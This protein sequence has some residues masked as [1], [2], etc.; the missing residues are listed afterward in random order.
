MIGEEKRRRGSSNGTAALLVDGIGEVNGRAFSGD[1]DG[2]QY[3]TSPEQKPGWP[4]FQSRLQSSLSSLAP[5]PV[6]GEE[7]GGDKEQTSQHRQDH[8]LP[9]EQL[10]KELAGKRDGKN[11][12]GNISQVASGE[13]TSSL[14]HRTPSLTQ[15][16]REIKP[17]VRMSAVFSSTTAGGSQ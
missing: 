17:G 9:G 10:D 13:F 1:V 11:S 2:D 3:T 5:P 12:F 16:P 8:S 6:G 14:V 15:P 4:R 7:K